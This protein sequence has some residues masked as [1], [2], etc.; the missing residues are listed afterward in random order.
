M[1]ISCGD[2]DTSA[3]FTCHVIILCHVSVIS[4]FYERIT[5][6]ASLPGHFTFIKLPTEF[7]DIII[8]A[9]VF[10]FIFPFFPCQ[11]RQKMYIS[12]IE[13]KLKTTSQIFKILTFLKRDFSNLYLI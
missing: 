11:M 6:N 8:N 1:N 7:A 9:A 4:K 2:T 10:V 12:L 5:Q 13:R 3:L